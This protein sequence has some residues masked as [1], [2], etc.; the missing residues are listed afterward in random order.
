VTIED[1]AVAQKAQI[2]RATDGNY[3]TMRRATVT[4]VSPFIISI[5]GILIDSPA[6]SP[7]YSPRVNDVVLVL[8]DG[9]APYVLEAVNRTWVDFTGSLVWSSTGTQPGLNNGTKEAQYLLLD[10]DVCIYEGALSFGSS[11]VAGTG[12]YSVNLPFAAHIRG[13]PS[14]ASTPWVGSSKFFNGTNDVNGVMQIFGGSNVNFPMSEAISAA[15]P[16]GWSAT[17][18]N[19]PNSGSNM[20]WTITYR[21]A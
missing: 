10:N 14:G 1:L 12:A 2:A 7:Q 20:C 15:I 19:P 11:T 5:N 8:M 21:I 16:Q 3:T 9:A 17:A 18:P 4:S 6:C 13:T